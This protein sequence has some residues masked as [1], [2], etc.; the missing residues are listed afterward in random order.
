MK[1]TKQARRK[2][3]TLVNGSGQMIYTKP[4]K[5]Q[6]WSTDS[7]FAVA[8][9]LDV[10]SKRT[11]VRSGQP[12]IT[13]IAECDGN[14]VTLPAVKT[15]KSVSEYNRASYMIGNELVNGNFVEAFNLLGVTYKVDTEH[16]CNPI[17]VYQN[18]Q[19]I[20]LIMP[21]RT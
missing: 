4:Y 17:K 13:R 8:D 1:T 19:L 15:D 14:Y 11:I 7:Y 12:D 16:K 6:V 5:G 2:F 3:S 10:T 20:G 9:K 21:L 18:N